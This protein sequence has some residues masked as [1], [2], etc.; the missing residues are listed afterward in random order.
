MTNMHF[1]LTAEI[2]KNKGP[3]VMTE[4]ERYF[5]PTLPWPTQKGGEAKLPSD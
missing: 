2:R 4:Q 3:P 1:P 5:A